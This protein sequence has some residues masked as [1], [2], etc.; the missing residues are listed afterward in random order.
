ML[1]QP[2]NK[3]IISLHITA[4]LTGLVGIFVL[5]AGIVFLVFTST[6]ASMDGAGLSEDVVSGILVMI[7]FCFLG[8]L[9]LGTAIFIEI[10][11]H[12]LKCQRYWAWIAAIIISGINLPSIYFILG[13]VGI[14]GL[15]DKTVAKHYLERA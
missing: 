14:I 15:A 13:L 4:I 7:Y 10:V 12:Y 6:D 2:I 3:A 5:G 9:L 8:I 11:I 1:P